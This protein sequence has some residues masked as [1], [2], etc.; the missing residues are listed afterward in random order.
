MIIYKQLATN[1]NALHAIPKSRH[2]KGVT[3]KYTPLRSS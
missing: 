3:G 1:M 2:K